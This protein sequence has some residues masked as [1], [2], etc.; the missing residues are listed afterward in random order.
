MRIDYENTKDD[1]LAFNEH[2]FRTSP[3]LQRQYRLGFAAA[4]LP[5]IGVVAAITWLRP[6]LP[7]WVAGLIFIVTAALFVPFYRRQTLR[8][9]HKTVLGTL[10]EGRNEGVLARH[11]IELIEG[12]LRE[13]TEVGESTHKW[14]GVERIELTEDFILLFTQATGGYIVPRRAF[15][16]PAEA[17]AFY[18]EATRLWGEAR[19]SNS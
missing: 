14:S 17:I 10:G 13:R 12:E 5:G 6:G 2:F 4:P 3:A 16:T 1:L 15:Q 19:S 8:T 7:L 18:E 11:E 9:L